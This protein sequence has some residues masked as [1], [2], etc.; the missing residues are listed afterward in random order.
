MTG[1]SDDQSA[2]PTLQTTRVLETPTMCLRSFFSSSRARD[3]T[4]RHTAHD[5]TTGGAPDQKH[6]HSDRIATRLRKIFRRHCHMDGHETNGSSSVL[7]LVPTT[8]AQ[9]YRFESPKVTK[10]LDF[11]TAPSCTP[12]STP[13]TTD[14]NFPSPPSINTPPTTPDSFA[15]T[16]S[17][18][19]TH[20]TY[21]TQEYKA[22]LVGLRDAEKLLEKR[23]TA[24]KTRPEVTKKAAFGSAVP[25]KKGSSPAG[26]SHLPAHLPLPSHEQRQ[27]THTTND[28][29]DA[30]KRHQL[31]KDLS[32]RAAGGCDDA[33]I[34]ME[35][36]NAHFVLQHRHRN[37]NIPNLV[38]NFDGLLVRASDLRTVE[39]TWI[40]RFNTIRKLQAL[41][42]RK[43][44]SAE[45]F[46][47]VATQLYPVGLKEIMKPE[48]FHIFVVGLANE[49]I[50]TEREAKS[51]TN[52]AVSS[53]EFEAGARWTGHSSAS[54]RYAGQYR[55]D[56]SALT[57]FDIPKQAHSNFSLGSGRTTPGPPNLYFHLRILVEAALYKQ[58]F[59]KGYF[60]ANA[61]SKLN[62][63]YLAHRM[64]QAG[65]LLPPH[66]TDYKRNWTY[67]EGRVLA[68]GHLVCTLLSWFEKGELT[69]FGIVRAV[70]GTFCH[71]PGQAYWDVEELSTFLYHRVVDSGLPFPTISDIL[72]LHPDND[73]NFA[74]VRLRAQVLRELAERAEMF[75]REEE[76]RLREIEMSVTTFESLRKKE[77]G[78]RKRMKVAVKRLFGCCK[79]VAVA[80]F[81]PFA[82]Q[83][84]RG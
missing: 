66:L 3:A 24:I 23:H 8:T 18:G 34:V 14:S 59:W 29:W 25:N 36:L 39:R 35:E 79:E 62:D 57:I 53:E 80:P 16:I 15:L 78:R 68:R 70:R 55:R 4:L 83:H 76:Q 40:S 61:Q 47:Q 52:L 50:I 67:H 17:P 28:A 69:D 64:T 51:F 21:T 33:I 30:L 10:T 27:Q 71:L 49:G 44:V 45:D 38:M 58:Q 26:T 46:E 2:S 9:L 42:V 22:A 41:A 81:D 77:M 20:K 82:E 12:T 5:S 56:P 43:R 32:Y 65:K 72:A 75:E 19:N 54:N 74:N 48:Y 31:I 84:E 6:G 11:E 7:A 63:Y 60:F 1:S 13:G 37:E 73:T